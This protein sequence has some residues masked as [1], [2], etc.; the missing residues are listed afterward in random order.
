MNRDLVE[1]RIRQIVGAFRERWG[2]LIGVPTLQILGEHDQ[3]MARRQMGEGRAE[4]AAGETHQ[5]RR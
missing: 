5:H 2:K 4:K 1:G 3:R